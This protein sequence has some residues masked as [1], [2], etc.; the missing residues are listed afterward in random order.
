MALKK[1]PAKKT[2]A[3]PAKAAPKSTPAKPAADVVTAQ[4][5]LKMFSDAFDALNEFKEMG[6]FEGVAFAGT[7]PSTG[8]AAEPVRE[9]DEEKTRALSIA[10][11]RALAS[12]L[13]LEEQ[14]L[15]SGILAELE[16][17]G[18]FDG[19]DADDEDEEE[20]VEEDDTD[21]DDEDEEDEDDEEDDLPSRDEL[22]EMDI[23]ELRALAKTE[24]HKLADYKGLDQEG[25]ITLILGEDEEDDEDDEEEEVDEDQLRAMPLDEL[26]AL[27]KEMGVRVP[28]NVKQPALVELILDAAEED[29]DE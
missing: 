18:F 10:E 12:E 14:K 29:E 5:V 8:T 2:T 23:K 3:A 28:R 19:E 9:L 20:D 1:S 11:L 4:S 16:E 17:K 26:K 27:A 6:G 25:L 13:G 24:G 7:K 21:E 22:E 15:K